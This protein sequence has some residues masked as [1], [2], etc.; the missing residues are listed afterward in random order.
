MVTIEIKEINLFSEWKWNVH[1][2]ECP[3]CNS[4]IN[5]PSIETIGICK[6]V[7]HKEC[8]NMWIKKK[9]TCPLCCIKWET[10]N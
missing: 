4:E 6:H 3:I 5:D 2:D 1:N 8:I 9:N 7:Y 10:K